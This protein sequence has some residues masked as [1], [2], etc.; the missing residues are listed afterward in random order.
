MRK[1]FRWIINFFLFLMDHW[2]LVLY[3]YCIF[4]SKKTWTLKNYHKCLSYFTIINQLVILG[5]KNSASSLSILFS[6]SLFTSQAP[7]YQH[8]KKSFW[9]E[10]KPR[11]KQKIVIVIPV[12]EWTKSGNLNSR[13]QINKWQRRNWN[14]D[15]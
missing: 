12:F 11:L 7:W 8:V 13:Y 3:V 10:W 9:E 2:T 1:L 6:F 5:G 15:L 4:G 14:S